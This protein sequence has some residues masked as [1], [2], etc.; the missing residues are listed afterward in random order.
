ME[1]GI[2]Y[3]FVD[4]TKRKDIPRWKIELE[5]RIYLEENNKNFPDLVN[6]PFSLTPEAVLPEEF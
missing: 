4:P 1:K 3:N 5:A 2:E 6:V